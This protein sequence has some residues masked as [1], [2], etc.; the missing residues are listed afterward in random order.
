[1]SPAL[2]EDHQQNDFGEN[3]FH[4]HCS[5]SPHFPLLNSIAVS[6]SDSFCLVVLMAPFVVAST[7]AGNACIQLVGNKP[8]YYRMGTRLILFTKRLK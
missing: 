2:K 7:T 3:V 8:S 4:V 6:S 5:R 1:M